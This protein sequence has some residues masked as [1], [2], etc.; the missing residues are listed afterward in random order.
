MYFKLHNIVYNN[1]TYLSP[2]SQKAVLQ[3]GE[4]HTICFLCFVLFIYS[5]FSHRF[6]RTQKK[7]MTASCNIYKKFIVTYFDLL[8]ETFRGKAK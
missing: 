8:Q 1:F 6:A 2:E 5:F 3:K 7:V 4:S